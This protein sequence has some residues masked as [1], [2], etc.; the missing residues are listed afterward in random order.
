MIMY[1]YVDQ[2]HVFLVGHAISPNRGSEPGNTWN[3]AWELSRYTNVDVFAYPQYRNEVE[4]FILKHPRQ[5]LRFNW[6]TLDG[7]DPWRPEKGE[8]G[9]RFHYVL[10]L[11]KV[12][13]IIKNLIS[14]SNKQYVVHHVSWATVSTP[15]PILQ[16]VP[17]VWGP[18]SGGQVAPANFQGFLAT[19]G[20]KKW[21]ALGGFL[22][23]LGCLVGGVVCLLCH[24][25]LL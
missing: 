22:S 6:V 3:W 25:S 18:V 12:Y 20:Q 10:W 23:F 1:K 2:T 17:V 24:S 13:K 7:F 9:I 15:P 11:R 21:Y 16:G 19:H 8:R 14:K 4:A 5:N